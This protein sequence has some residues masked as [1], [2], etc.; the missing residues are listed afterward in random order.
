MVERSDFF[1]G[2]KIDV[3]DFEHVMVSLGLFRC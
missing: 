3:C 2:L 1:F